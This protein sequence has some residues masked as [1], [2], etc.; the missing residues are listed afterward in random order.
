MAKTGSHL[1]TFL[2]SSSRWTDFLEN[3]VRTCPEGIIANDIAGSIFLFNASAERIFGYAAEEV[4]GRFEVSRLYPPGGARDVK[5]FL[6]SEEYGGRGH[7][8]D[9]ETE[10]VHKDGRRIPIR[11]CCAL[12]Q[13][14]GRE[15]GTIGFFTDITA[16][17]ALLDRFLESEERFRGIFET[18]RDAMVSIG[19]DG[20]VLMANR[21]AEEMLGYGEGEL[22]GTE[23]VRLFPP[24]LGDYWRELAL[25]ASR[26]EPGKERGNIE[27][28]ALTR[29]GREFPVQV[30]LAEK[31][32]RGGKILTVILR[33]VSERK[34]LEDELRLQ[35]ITD[36]LTGLYNRRHF[37]S[38][39][40]TE[41]ERARRHQA[42]FSILLIDVDWFK[43][44]NDSFGHGEGD[45]V[46]KAVG[47][48]IRE[49][50]RTID[51][52]FRYGGEEFLVLLPGTPPDGAV[53]S[54]ERLRTRFSSV[55]FRPDPEADPR[56]VTLSIGVA[57]YRDGFSVDDLV[58]AADRA[59]Y[60][61]KNSGRN[62]TVRTDGLDSRDLP[63]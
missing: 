27:M 4:L 35:S 54:A 17:K 45:V 38:L 20:R 57:G 30:T 48:A 14:D 59:M 41:M 42:P 40:E 10:V 34:S 19:E 33:D 56:S 7:L 31:S 44:Y 18:A 15:I 5:E 28:S 49:N 11:L 60:T 37:L 50:F 6:Y 51:T 53:V 63:D 39:V 9:F 26:M 36:A 32:T 61:A 16:R 29:S 52:G 55:P 24:R 12:L 46:L 22:P 2:D 13:E 25:Y 43:Q 23:A 1:A 3:V 58:R 21:A 47:N 62:R 8:V